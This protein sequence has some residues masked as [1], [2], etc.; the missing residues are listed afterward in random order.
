M[1]LNN[2]IAVL[3]GCVHEFVQPDYWGIV[4]AVTVPVAVIVVLICIC[5]LCCRALS[6]LS[7]SGRW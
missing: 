5:S 7:H 2:L 1:M 3:L 6:A 4:D